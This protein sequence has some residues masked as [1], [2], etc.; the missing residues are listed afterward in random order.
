MGGTLTLSGENVRGTTLSSASSNR[1]N[2][3]LVRQG[4]CCRFYQ[5][6]PRVLKGSL[7]VGDLDEPNPHGWLRGTEG[8]PAQSLSSV[9]CCPSSDRQSRSRSCMPPPHEVEHSFQDPMCSTHLGLPACW[10]VLSANLKSAPCNPCWLHC[11]C[12]RYEMCLF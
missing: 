10:G 1:L 9:S 4:A 6:R 11:G 2:A 7:G 3:R 12:L 5:S 8:K